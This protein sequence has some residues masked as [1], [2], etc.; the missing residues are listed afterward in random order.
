MGIYCILILPEI[1]LCGLNI[2]QGVCLSAYVVQRRFMW[3]ISVWRR[4]VFTWLVI[5]LC[6]V[7][8]SSRLKQWLT[9]P[10]STYPGVLHVLK[11]R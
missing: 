5:T 6:V 2:F 4:A 1:I 9:I 3:G 7:G 10:R 11:V 8:I